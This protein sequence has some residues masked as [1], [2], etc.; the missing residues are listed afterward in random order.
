M[1]GSIHATVTA[2]EHSRAQTMLEIEV[3]KQACSEMHLALADTA[4]YTP[5][6]L[7]D[8]QYVTEQ[9]HL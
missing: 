5:P 1:I 8:P 2:L 3:V 4:Q 9:M 7:S 6:C